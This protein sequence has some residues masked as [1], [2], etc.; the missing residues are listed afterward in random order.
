MKHT[1]YYHILA[2]NSVSAGGGSD[3]DCACPQALTIDSPQPLA[4]DTIIQC[5]ENLGQIRL[6]DEYSAVFVPSFS[7]VVVLNQA[8]LALL[9][10]LRTACPVATLPPEALDA[11]QQL[12]ALGLLRERG[13]VRK[14]PPPPDELVA[15]LHVTNACNLRCTYCYV[16][17]TDEAMPAET[18]YAAVDAILRAAR[19]HGYQRVLLKYAGGEASLN[20]PLVEEIQRYATAQAN[21]I[22]VRGV[23]LS[24][25]VGLTRNKLQRIVDMGLRLMISLDGPE[26][27]HDAQRPRRG[28]QG[29]FAAVM[30]SIERAKAMGVDLTV[31]VTVT[32]HSVAGLP[33]IVAWLLERDLQFSLNFY[34]ENDCSVSFS[35]LQ[36]NEQHLIE[37]MRAAY[38]VIEQ[39]LPNYS[40]LGTLIDRANLGAAHSRTCA[41]GENYMVIDHHGNVAKCQMEMQRPVTSIWADDPLTV[42][43]LDQTGVQNL[44]VEQKEGCRECQWRFWCAGGCAI[45]TFRATGR[46]DIKSPNCAIYQALY[47][48]VIRL[49]GLRLL[50]SGL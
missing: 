32:G 21:G 9:Q 3:C 49:E 43:R 10:E 22:A 8:A 7:R 13:S 24:N 11:V 28:G 4:P 6:S 38:R 29:S 48:D 26:E 2:D 36:I 18:A 23:V 41:V 35:E 45:A 47:P 14:A 42:I 20:L 27:Y 1:T 33:Q 34:R 31:S 46:Y 16:E 37:G 17:K 39:H 19:T 25:G 50:Q 40:L 12:F 30:A 15:W 5:D 44:P